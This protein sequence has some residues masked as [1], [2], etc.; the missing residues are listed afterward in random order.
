[1]KIE[2]RQLPQTFQQFE[3]IIRVE[4]R[5][6]MQTLQ[7]LFDQ[8]AKNGQGVSVRGFASELVPHFTAL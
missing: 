8:A 7:N 1:M 2:S 5:Q 6:D 3:V 4:T